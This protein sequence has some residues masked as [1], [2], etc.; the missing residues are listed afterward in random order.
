MGAAIVPP[1]MISVQRLEVVPAGHEKQYPRL[2]AV[3]RDPIPLKSIVGMSGGPIIG[4]AGDERELRYWIVAL[5]S[6]WLPSSRTIFA[7]PVPVF[8][9]M[10]VAWVRSEVSPPV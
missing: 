10:L 2:T 4:F 6:A 5:Q 3:I 1:T 8:A 9:P 7:C